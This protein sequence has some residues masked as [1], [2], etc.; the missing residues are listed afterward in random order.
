[1][2]HLKNV[3]RAAV[4]ALVT[5]G[6]AGRAVASDLS[7]RITV[8]GEPAG[9]DVVIWIDG[10]V[11]AERAPKHAVL[12]Q[13]GIRFLPTFLVVSVGQT[14]EMPNDDNVAHNVYSMSPAKKFN[15]GVYGKGESRS[16][17]FD[18]PGWVDLN[19]WLHK[20]M[21]AK[22]LVVPN[23]YF[24]RANNGTYHISGLPPGTYKIVATRFGAPNAA[25]K[26]VVTSRGPVII[27]FNL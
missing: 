19:C 17:T 25:K 5:L 8:G 27:D 2:E 22:I 12:V 11:P 9:D 18:K 10:P 7:G 16:V 1:M 15:L 24:A 13:S 3:V 6:F 20:R 4:V 23:P 14:V 21:N 26:A